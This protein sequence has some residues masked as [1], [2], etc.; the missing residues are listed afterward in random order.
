MLFAGD[1]ATDEDIFRS[2]SSES[3]TIKIGAGQTAAGWSLNSPAELL[4]LL[5]KLSSA[6]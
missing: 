2:I 3:Y 6:D 5:K 4:E 1:D